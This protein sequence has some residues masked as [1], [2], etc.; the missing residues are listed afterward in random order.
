MKLRIFP[1]ALIGSL[2]FLVIFWVVRSQTLAGAKMSAEPGTPS[3]QAFGTQTPT[4][5]DIGGSLPVSALALQRYAHSAIVTQTVAGIDLSVT[6]LR[7]EKDDFFKIKIAV[8]VCYRLPDNKDWGIYE[9]IV[10]SDGQQFLL[11]GGTLLEVAEAR[12]DGTK[13]IVRFEGQ[14]MEVEDVPSDG[15]SYRCDALSFF[16]YPPLAEGLE[17]SSAILTIK[18]LR[19]LP[20]E[21]QDCEFYL[22]AVQEALKQDGAGIEL[23]CTQGEWGRYNLQIVNKLAGMSE[24]E[25]RS[26]V[27]QYA[28]R[29]WTVEGPWVFE[30]KL[31]SADAWLAMP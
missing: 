5:S 12:E 2:L 29:V 14:G 3:G 6:N 7:Y 8:D 23:A 16:P 21:G 17:L 30:G 1:L 24:K 28:D 4:A 10:Q 15:V 27:M 18:S 31:I 20:R 25:A 9:A 26:V 19:A 11:H 22:T 13:H